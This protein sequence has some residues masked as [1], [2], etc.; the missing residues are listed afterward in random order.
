MTE[1]DWLKCRK[2]D[3][4][5]RFLL[6][7]ASPPGQGW[8]SRAVSL[9]SR[10]W[11][12][13]RLRKLRLFICACYRR[14]GNGSRLEVER[15]VQLYE[16]YAE[17]LVPYQAVNEAW[18]AAREVWGP[19]DGAEWVWV[20][21]EGNDLELDRIE[22]HN[23]NSPQSGSWEDW[24]WANELAEEACQTVPGSDWVKEGNAQCDLLRHLFGN[25]FGPSPKHAPWSLAVSQLVE[26]LSQGEAC[27]FA[28]HDA[29]LE[30]GHPD[31]AEHFQKEE[32]HPNGCWAMDL[33][34]G[35]K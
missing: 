22:W 7:R 17:G 4:M 1:E 8:L 24:Y 33:L 3:I 12:R 15:F 20:D 6:A 23:W 27:S 25:P 31:L 10:S 18:L 16:R 13:R 2:P 32:R 21:S 30:A 28:L 26:S 19:A 5:L 9:V 34:L 11:V 14:I 35:K 29:L